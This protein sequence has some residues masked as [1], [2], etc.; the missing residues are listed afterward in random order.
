VARVPEDGALRVALADAYSRAFLE[1]WGPRAAADQAATAACA[2]L[3]GTAPLPWLGALAARQ[4]LGR[5]D[6]DELARRYLVP[7]L[8][9]YLGARD[10]CPLL[11]APQVQLAALCDRLDRSDGRRAYLERAVR[12]RPS[13]AELW[14]LAGAEQLRDGDP[15]RAWESWRRSLECSD[16]FLGEIVR[17]S[18]RRLG[19]EAAAREV[20]PGRPELLLRAAAEVAPPEDGP[21]R[22]P[23]L[24]R[25]LALV[26]ERP[27]ERG[28]NDW[29]LEA[30]IHVAL[31]R[32][33]EALDAYRAALARAPL[34]AGWRYELARLLHEQGR[35]E[36]AARE[37]RVVVRQQPQNG[38]ARDLLQAVLR[39]LTEDE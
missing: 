39:E 27:G 28:A 10:A 29:H 23:F 15:G 32:P 3:A 5:A 8:R 2:V 13:D 18:C 38:D 6:D 30:Q 12:L 17:D 20:L 9:H 4:E 14:Y 11:V 25:A 21:R 7:A 36:D 1:R 26:R 31:G 24:A 22:A 19:P 16:A 34:H 35:R 37:L 33:A